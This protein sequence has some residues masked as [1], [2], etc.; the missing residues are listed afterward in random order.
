MPQVLQINVEHAAWLAGHLL[1]C[2]R[3]AAAASAS[4][5]MK[6]VGFFFCHAAVKRPGLL[7]WNLESRYNISSSTPF[8]IQT[9]CH[10]CRL[11]GNIVY[12]VCGA[13]QNLGKVCTLPDPELKLKRQHEK[14]EI[15]G[16]YLYSGAVTSI[17]C[18][19]T[20]SHTYGVNVGDS[21]VILN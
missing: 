2:N 7:S 4:A 19:P 18:A 17:I 11:R 20:P 21:S 1:H 13:L 5:C 14:N 12:L 16:S 3:E 10:T 15:E 9:M 8:G 6:D